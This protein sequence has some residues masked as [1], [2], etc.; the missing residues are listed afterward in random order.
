VGVTVKPLD[1]ISKSSSS[2]RG[3]GGK[4][5][6][7]HRRLDIQTGKISIYVA[8]LTLMYCK[9]AILHSLPSEAITRSCTYTESRSLLRLGTSNQISTKIHLSTSGPSHLSLHTKVQLVQSP[10]GPPSNKLQVIFHIDYE[11]HTV[12]H[13]S[14]VFNSLL[15]GLISP[16]QYSPRIPGAFRPSP[17][18]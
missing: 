9:A 18:V 17:Q 14:E 3:V 13:A 15:A 1:I 16:V 2:S 8:F 7:L 4:Q 10:I 5:E 11:N 6:G 12:K